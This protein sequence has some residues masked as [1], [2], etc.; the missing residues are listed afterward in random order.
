MFADLN[1]T[2]AAAV[3]TSVP[4]SFP[5]AFSC[6]ECVRRRDVVAGTPLEASKEPPKFGARTRPATFVCRSRKLAFA[7]ACVRHVLIVA[8]SVFFVTLFAFSHCPCPSVSAFYSFFVL[9]SRFFCWFCGSRGAAREAGA[10]VGG[11]DQDAL[12]EGEG[13]IHAAAHPL[14]AG[15]AHQNLW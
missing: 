14:G 2:I 12:R 11:G 7:E 10:A 4:P 15:G 8:V 3:V 5:G 13:H 9:V 1:E 6:S